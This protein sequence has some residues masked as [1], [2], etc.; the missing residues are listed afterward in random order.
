[1]AVCVSV[2]LCKYII[3]IHVYAKYI[4]MKITYLCKHRN[5]EINFSFDACY[6]E[7]QGIDST[8]RNFIRSGPTCTRQ[9]V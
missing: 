5:G 4:H 9:N 6:W 1:M 3:E 7:K 8:I 2:C